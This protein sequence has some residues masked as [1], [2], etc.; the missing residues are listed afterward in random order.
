MKTDAH[1]DRRAT[2]VSDEMSDDANEAPCEVQMREN[3]RKLH[4]KEAS[5][6][7]DDAKRSVTLF[8]L[9]SR[10]NGEVPSSVVRGTCTCGKNRRTRDWR[11]AHG[12]NPEDGHRTA[13]GQVSDAKKEKRG[14]RRRLQREEGRVEMRR[15]GR[16]EERSM[17][18]KRDGER[19][20]I[21]WVIRARV[22]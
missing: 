17:V 20:I 16:S 9:R 15:E 10:K 8:T 1:A 18:W 4:S 14:R 3:R 7:D 13:V 22:W 19:K 2:V 12:G 6:R 11:Q 5:I 21:I